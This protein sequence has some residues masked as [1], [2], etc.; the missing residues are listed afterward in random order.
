MNISDEQLYRSVPIIDKAIND[1]LMEN[2]DT[3][4]VF[5]SKFLKRMEKILNAERNGYYQSNWFVKIH[6]IAV[7]FII[8]IL[9]LGSTGTIVNAATDGA[10][11][12]YIKGICFGSTNGAQSNFYYSSDDSISVSDF[13]KGAYQTTI[14][15]RGEGIYEFED[16]TEVPFEKIVFLYIGKEYSPGDIVDV[17]ILP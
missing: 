3:K 2:T 17:I 13:P 16:G 6:K 8:V 15:Y 14:I 9:L 11:W 12:E 7:A 10:L 4:H 1:Y 5:S